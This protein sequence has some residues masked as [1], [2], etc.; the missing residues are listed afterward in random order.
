MTKQGVKKFTG[1]LVL[2]ST[3]L[4]LLAGIVA[5]AY[6]GP[7]IDTDREGEGDFGIW[8]CYVEAEAR[9]HYAT[10]ITN[11]YE[12][13]EHV[14]ERWCNEV[15]Y[16]YTGDM[17]VHWYGDNYDPWGWYS[18][19]WGNSAYGYTKDGDESY[20]STDVYSQTRSKFKMW[21]GGTTDYYVATAAV[22]ASA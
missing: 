20:W 16:Y 4:M 9:G 12:W 2:L 22:C 15:F 13:N 11:A 3:L 7:D 19:T 10:G 8:I 21:W 18:W 1:S 14:S 6:P 17:E 5:A